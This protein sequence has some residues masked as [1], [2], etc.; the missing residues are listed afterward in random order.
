MRGVAFATHGVQW[1]SALIHHKVAR[2]PCRGL[3]ANGGGVQGCPLPH[4]FAVRK[5]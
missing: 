3:A 2:A 4:D 1:N 5:V